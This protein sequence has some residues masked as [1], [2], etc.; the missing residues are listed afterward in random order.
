MVSIVFSFSFSA[1]WD[2]KSIGLKY[3]YEF[4]IV[5]SM[6]LETFSNNN[7]IITIFPSCNWVLLS[8]KQKGDLGPTKY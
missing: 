6:F 1:D 3:I 2:H 5:N 8:L 4:D 7:D